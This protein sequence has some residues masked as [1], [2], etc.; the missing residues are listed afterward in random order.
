MD[1]DHKPLDTV[2]R[3]RADMKGVEE[4]G[5]HDTIIRERLICMCMHV[6]KFEGR[7][8]LGR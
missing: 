3:L 7:E 4:E 8:G 5:I 2:V 1:R 6:K